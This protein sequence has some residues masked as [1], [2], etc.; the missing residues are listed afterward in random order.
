MNST[1]VSIRLERMHFFLLNGWMHFWSMVAC[2]LRRPIQARRAP[3]PLALCVEMGFRWR[4]LSTQNA[5][6]EVKFE[7]IWIWTPKRN[8]TLL[9]LFYF[10]INVRVKTILTH[11]APL[12]PMHSV[13]FYCNSLDL[14]VIKTALPPRSNR[15]DLW[16]FSYFFLL[17]YISAY[18]ELNS[19]SYI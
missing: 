9:P 6:T 18:V 12:C 16:F 2:K 19:T 15:T 11:S 14:I 5:T 1:S 7:V 3:P 17:I 10:P 13:Q 4:F 8:R